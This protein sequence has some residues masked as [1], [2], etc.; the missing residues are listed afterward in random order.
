M[1]SDD[2]DGWLREQAQITFNKINVSE[3]TDDISKNL[4]FIIILLED[5]KQKTSEDIKFIIDCSFQLIKA[6]RQNDHHCGVVKAYFALHRYLDFN[7]FP[8]YVNDER[9]I[10]TYVYQHIRS[11]GFEPADLFQTVS[12]FDI[13][14]KQIKKDSPST[15]DIDLRASALRAFTVK[16]MMIHLEKYKAYIKRDTTEYLRDLAQRDGCIDMTAVLAFSREYNISVVIIDSKQGELYIIKRT[17]PAKTI[18]VGYETDYRFIHLKQTMLNPVL[19]E[20]IKQA[21]TDVFHEKTFSKFNV[22]GELL[23]HSIFYRTDL[24][25]TTPALHPH[26][27]PFLK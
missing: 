7:Q 17:K 20:K 19:A 2:N 13:A 6:Y 12:F 27:G 18:Y 3:P 23:S 9:E 8:D 14:T 16:H 11:Y 21:P 10:N 25:Q 4:S 22:K 5:I 26:P 24:F 1:Q 15:F